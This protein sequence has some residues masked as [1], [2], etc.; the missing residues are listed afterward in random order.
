MNTLD[1][2]REGISA[3]VELHPAALIEIGGLPA[4]RAALWD[5]HD[6][7]LTAQA[8]LHLYEERWS[9]IDPARMSAPERALLDRLVRDVGNG[10]FLD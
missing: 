2:A 4:L 1:V 7:V 3:N 8:L 6:T 5:R 10:V 9:Y